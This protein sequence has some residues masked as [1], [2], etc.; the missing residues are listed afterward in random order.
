M[1]KGSLL[2]SPS[3]GTNTEA[4]A[5]RF[6]EDGAIQQLPQKNQV[7]ET[8]SLSSPPTNLRER[9]KGKLFFYAY[10]CHLCSTKSEKEPQSVQLNPGG[11]ASTKMLPEQE[12]SP[13]PDVSNASPE[14]RANCH[15]AGKVFHVNFT[16]LRISQELM[17][18]SCEHDL[19]FVDSR[20][21]RKEDMSGR[22]AAGTQEAEP[23]TAERRRELEHY[24]KLK[25]YTAVCLNLG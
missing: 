8:V 6:I 11:I 15:T 9:T 20:R 19:S 7:S 22:Q 18:L 4:H 1:F 24:L 13:K 16:V 3:A 17:C 14:T 23:P 10:F 12:A 25:R 2:F 21:R 5:P